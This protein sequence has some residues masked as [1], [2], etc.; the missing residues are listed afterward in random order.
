MS[1]ICLKVCSV[2]LQDD[3]DT[4]ASCKYATNACAGGTGPA[5]NTTLFDRV[6]D[7]T[8][9]PR[10]LIGAA[11]D[12]ATTAHLKSF[13]AGAATAARDAGNGKASTTRLS[14]L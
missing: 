1:R 12:V 10:F 9:F 3:A 6:C 2:V 13:R 8:A 5:L 14:R 4:C 7:A 11:A